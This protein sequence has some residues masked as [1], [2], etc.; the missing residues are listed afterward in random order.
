MESS[1]GIDINNSIKTLLAKIKSEI[2]N[3]NKTLDN[4]DISLLT[5][6][7]ES[8]EN[9]YNSLF[10][11]SE[12]SISK[13][14]EIKTELEESRSNLISQ[15]DAANGSIWSVDKDLQIKTINTIFANNY[16]IAFGVKLKKG[17]SVINSLPKPLKKIWEE[18]YQ[19]ALGGEQF[20]IVDHFEIKDIPQYIETS[21]NPVNLNNKIVGVACFARDMSEQ[22]KAENALK[23]SEQR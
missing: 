12:D 15:I 6:R 2:G 17:V 23:E 14:L 11:K 16:K 1:G 21:F 10:I 4:G 7:I 13:L 5:K 3:G 18:R 19:R 9:L 20:S 22:K 8:L